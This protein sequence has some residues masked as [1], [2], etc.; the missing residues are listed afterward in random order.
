[1][2]EQNKDP[3]EDSN[4][5]FNCDCSSFSQ[6]LKKVISNSPVL[7]FQVLLPCLY[8]LF[9]HLMCFINFYVYRWTH[10]AVVCY[11]CCGVSSFV[12]VY[13]DWNSCVVSNQEFVFLFKSWYTGLFSVLGF[14]FFI[15]MYEIGWV[16]W[17]T[18]ISK[19]GAGLKCGQMMRLSV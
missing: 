9:I 1:M 2:Q 8:T 14:F 19:K 12:F 5:G 13:N 15:F 10:L 7:G 16:C 6:S 18:L 11:L 4:I 3:K 17:E